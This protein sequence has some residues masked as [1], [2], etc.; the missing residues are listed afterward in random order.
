MAASAEQWGV[1]RAFTEQGPEKEGGDLKI[2]PTPTKRP[3]G[4]TQAFPAFLRS[5]ELQ[6]HQHHP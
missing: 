6:Y 2:S 3:P 1:E 4:E 5:K